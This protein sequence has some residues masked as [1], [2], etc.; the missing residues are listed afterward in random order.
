MTDQGI[1]EPTR[2]DLLSSL[3]PALRQASIASAA[4]QAEVQFL[5]AAIEHE[6]S[7]VRRAADAAAACAAK[8]AHHSHAMM[9][10]NELLAFWTAQDNNN[11]ESDGRHQTTIGNS[12]TN[13]HS[14]PSLLLLL[15]STGT[16]I[17][18]DMARF[19]TKFRSKVDHH[20][21]TLRIGSL[22][23]ARKL[24]DA[25][26]QINRTIFSRSSWPCNNNSN[27]NDKKLN[28]DDENGSTDNAE[29][30]AHRIN[31]VKAALVAAWE[32]ATAIEEFEEGAA[33]VHLATRM[34]QK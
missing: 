5:A 25:A 24:R 2:L 18:D 23:P 27:N 20:S 31:L 19:T 4:L 3:G 30:S 13:N 7:V 34:A 29:R 14:A 32:E 6:K 28:D 17:L 22:V 26:V 15:H 8:I 16:Q 10:N 21:R 12:N 33:T 9:Q 1:N 11:K